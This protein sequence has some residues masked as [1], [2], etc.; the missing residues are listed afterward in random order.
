MTTWGQSK[1][2][3]NSQGGEVAAMRNMLDQYK[4][5]TP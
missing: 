5:N 4:T 3:P 2:S 1:T